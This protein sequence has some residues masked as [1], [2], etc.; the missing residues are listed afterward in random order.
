MGYGLIIII[1]NYVC[2]WVR[3]ISNLKSIK[4]ERNSTISN[5][6]EERN[7][8]CYGDEAVKFARIL[9]L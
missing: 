1:I 2:K 8:T 3:E 5:F 7:T 6:V 9:P 4:F